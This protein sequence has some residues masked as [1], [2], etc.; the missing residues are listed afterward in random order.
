MADQ[1]SRTV[2]SE[3]LGDGGGTDDYASVAAAFESAR[4][5]LVTFDGGLQDYRGMSAR[6]RAAYRDAHHRLQANAVWLQNT[7]ETLTGE[8]RVVVD[9]RQL[10]PLPYVLDGSSRQ[11]TQEVIESRLDVSGIFGNMVRRAIGEAKRRSAH[12]PTGRSASVI[13]VTSLRER[14]LR[15]L[16]YLYD[17]WVKRQG[18]YVEDPEVADALGLDRAVVRL[19]FDYLK[20]ERLLQNLMGDS[21]KMAVLIS[22]EGRKVAEEGWPESG[23]GDGSLQTITVTGDGNVIGQA[24]QDVRQHDPAD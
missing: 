22:H 13:A 19:D 12:H 11:N 24:G 8:R 21:R 15:I 7:I 3:W 5:D 1:P 9:G 2:A 18:R 10:D 17:Q 16:R 23:R 6:E 14:R 20:N 4:A